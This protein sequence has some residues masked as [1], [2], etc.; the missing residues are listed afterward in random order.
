MTR[1]PVAARDTYRRELLVCLFS[2]SLTT[3]QTV[4]LPAAGGSMR[5]NGQR[6][7][8]SRRIRFCLSSMRPERVNALTSLPPTGQT[9]TACSRADAPAT[10]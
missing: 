1:L 3:H 4:T 9:C 5:T 10:A 2:P 7:S 8:P 6:V